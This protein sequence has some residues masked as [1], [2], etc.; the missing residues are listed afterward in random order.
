MYANSSKILKVFTIILAVVVSALVIYA[1]F[2][3]KSRFYSPET[4]RYSRVTIDEKNDINELL[5][6]INDSRTKYKFVSEIKK[7]NNLNNLDNESVYGKTL[8]IP[9]INN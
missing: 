6:S 7:V 9:V 8:L 3:N 4:V 5:L 1:L 2:L